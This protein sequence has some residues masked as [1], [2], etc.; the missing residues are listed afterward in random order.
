MGGI[1]PRGGT[2]EIFA[3]TYNQNQPHKIEFQRIDPIVEWLSRLFRKTKSNRNYKRCS[4]SNAIDV[5]YALS[6]T[7]LQ[8]TLSCAAKTTV[9]LV[10]LRHIGDYSLPCGA[11]TAAVTEVYLVI[12]LFM[13]GSKLIIKSLE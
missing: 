13:F 10:V 2:N 4:K 8:F 1:S 6:Y 11:Q 5:T 12:F 9:I 7:P 3:V